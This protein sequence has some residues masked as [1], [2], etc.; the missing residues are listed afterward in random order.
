MQFTNTQRFSVAVLIALA[1][2]L[3]GNPP[4]AACP[5]CS[6]VAQT[7]TEEMNSMD[8]V[9]IVKLTKRPLPPKNPPEAGE[10][11]G[12][13]TFEVLEVLKGEDLVKIGSTIETLYFGEARTGT[14][15]IVMGVEPKKLLWSTPLVLSD[16]AKEYFY[17]LKKLPK[18]GTARLA[19]FQNYLEDE[20]EILARDA[21]DEFAN[22]PYDIVKG[23]KAQMKHDQLIAWIKDVEKIP[24]SRRRLYLTMLGVCGTESDLP[25]LE[26]L[27]KSTDRKQR[28]GLDALIACYLTLQGDSGVTLVEDLFLKNPKSDYADTYSAIMSLRFHATE[29]DILSKPR[30]IK[31]LRLMLN[32]AELAD[33]VI[34]DLARMD[35]WESVDRLMDLY[36]N[37][38]EKSSWVRVPVINY[39]R[40]CPDK[41]KTAPLLTECEKIDPMSMKRA[42]TFF[43]FSG[44]KPATP[45]ADKAS[46]TKPTGKNEVRKVTALE[47]EAG[48]SANGETAAKVKATVANLGAPPAE[49][50]L[51]QPREAPSWWWMLGIPGAIGGALFVVQWRILRGAAG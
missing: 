51:K 25:F 3:G 19:F 49:A 18:E 38:D 31:A 9:A 14:N 39:L 33:L 37:A 1:V 41:E 23:L 30:I 28:A 40:A 22:A 7:F 20:D 45:S 35:D 11:L 13:A 10:V 46:Q 34:P 16:R 6:A 24:A 8:A 32:R 17:Q 12:R 48:E 47:D 2:V 36:R 43:P 26:E 27:L 50:A 4:A 29:S 5:F 42:N 44:N 15:F 21:Y